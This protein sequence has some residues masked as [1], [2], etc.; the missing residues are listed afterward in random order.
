M[1]ETIKE[2]LISSKKEELKQKEFINKRMEE[3]NQEEKRL[4]FQAVDKELSEITIR[5]NE[6][7]SSSIKRI[8]NGKEITTLYEK[9]TN[10]SNSKIE[11]IDRFNN[12]RE[13]LLKKLY[14][15][16]HNEVLIEMEI[17]KIQKAKS[18]KELGL[19]EE[20][21]LSILKNYSKQNDQNI[22]KAVFLDIKNNQHITTREEIFKNMQNL[23]QTNASQF[24]LAMK[25]ILPTDLISNLID[26][27]II[28][29]EDK[30]EFLQELAS[31]TLS[32]THNLLPLIQ[33]LERTDRLDVY[34]YNE[35]EKALA[36]MERYS[37][38]PNTAISHIMTLSVLVSMAKANKLEKQPQK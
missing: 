26:V 17:D 12:E 28:I 8:F 11:K 32:P 30:M 1:L 9:Y 35:V 6:L 4:N 18:L 13:Q 19:T 5:L 27:N 37:N 7:M 38:Y 25:K 34:Y 16:A 23:Y 2:V 10:L 3:I 29:D 21:A 31:Y 33:K 15:L 22:I 36:N 14:E 24:V 20:Q